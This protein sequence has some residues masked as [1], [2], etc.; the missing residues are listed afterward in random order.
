[1]KS[2]IVIKVCPNP[3]CE[4]VYHN[5]PVQHKKCENCNTTIKMINYKTWCKKFSSNFFQYDFNTKEYY[6]PELVFANLNDVRDYQIENNS[7]NYNA[8]SV[9]G[10]FHGA[11]IEEKTEGAARRKF[12]DIFNGESII[13]IRKAWFYN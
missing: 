5:C 6:R 2:N 11:I 8:W 13:G 12:H 1:M 7:R 4:A 3:N 9:T 10:T